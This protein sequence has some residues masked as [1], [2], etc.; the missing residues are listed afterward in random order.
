MAEIG[1]VLAISGL[2]I[3]VAKQLND[4]RVKYKS[5]D[6][7]LLALSSECFVLHAALGRVQ[8]IRLSHPGKLSR[9]Q[10]GTQLAD[11]FDSALTACTLTLSALSFNLD[12]MGSVPKGGG[13]SS[14]VNWKG[15][16]LYLWNETE[17]K[18]ILSQ[19][20]GQQSALQ[21]LLLALN[22]YDRSCAD[23]YC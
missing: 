9:I 6:C 1:T 13:D 3:K 17:M 18:D 12:K 14:K 21:L 5:T 16:A 15:K 19:L 23:V 22:L 2:C 7:T 11:D 4:V 20:R 10:Q 8:S